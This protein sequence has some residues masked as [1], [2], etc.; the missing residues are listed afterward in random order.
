MAAAAPTAANGGSDAEKGPNADDH[1]PSRFTAVNGKEP[2]IS[3][4]APP[5]RDSHVPSVKQDQ[6]REDFETWRRGG[7][8]TPSQPDARLHGNDDDD[9]VDQG[10]RQAQRSPSRDEFSGISRGKR[11]R[12]DSG[13]H[14]EIEKPPYEGLG[15]SETPVPRFDDNVESRVLPANPSAAAIS[16][17]GHQAEHPSASVHPRNLPTDAPWQEHNSQYASLAQHSQQIE[18]SDA[19]IADVLQRGAQGEDQNG[20]GAASRVTDGS[21]HTNEPIPSSTY[22]RERSQGAVQVSRQRK[23]VFSNRTKTGCL[24]CRKRKKKCDERHPECKLTPRH[25][26]AL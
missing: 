20:L 10:D 14:R 15:V 24:T 19:H 25:C 21:V 11:K 8:N 18:P 13:G 1:S 17:G 7:H 6:R 3:G 23:R 5:V 4:L 9:Q 16:H 22:P 12:S 26:P 2:P